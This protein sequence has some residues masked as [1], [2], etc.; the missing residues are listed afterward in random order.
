LTIAGD[1]LTFIDHTA[2]RYETN[3]GS[4]AVL[5]DDSDFGPCVSDD[6]EAN[7]KVCNNRI[8]DTANDITVSD[9]S[10]HGFLQRCQPALRDCT[11]AANIPHNECLVIFGGSNIQM[12][13]NKFW[14]C[15]DTANVLIQASGGGQ[16]PTNMTW[17]GNW[18]NVSWN[19]LDGT[20]TN[21]K[22]IGLNV[23]A[24]ANFRGAWIFAFNTLNPCT[25]ANTGLEIP[26]IGTSNSGVSSSL[27]VGNIGTSAAGGGGGPCPTG[28]TA[29]RNVQRKWGSLSTCG[30]NTVLI[31]GSFPFTDVTKHGDFD[32]HWSGADGSQSA[33]GEDSVPTSV[34]GGCPGTDIDGATRPIDANCDAGSDER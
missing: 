6:D 17:V 33:L 16:L 23:G 34:S 15:G 3:A 30:T 26:W 7:N 10:H 18:F 1:D 8:V 27:I 28:M 2:V 4:N 25:T 21:E 31:V 11:L 29:D 19:A 24:K 14:D 9:T 12:L 13:R 32:H 5:I 22:C 20:A